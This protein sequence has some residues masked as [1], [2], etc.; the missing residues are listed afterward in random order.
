MRSLT[1]A[2]VCAQP[3]LL[4]LYDLRFGA[5]YRTLSLVRF[6]AVCLALPAWFLCGETHRARAAGR[7][8]GG[9]GGAIA[10]SGAHL[11]AVVYVGRMMPYVCGRFL[12]LT[13]PRKT[14]AGEA[15][16]LLVWNAANLTPA[17]APPLQFAFILTIGYFLNLVFLKVP[18][19]TP[20]FWLALGCEVSRAAGRESRAGTLASLMMMN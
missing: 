16:S 6:V 9:G 13:A 8:D 1:L 17:V 19:E 11:L 7:D 10:R 4:A 5:A 20:V 2:V 12:T 15:V 14:R 18:V 3:F